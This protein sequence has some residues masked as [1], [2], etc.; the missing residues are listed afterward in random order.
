MKSQKTTGDN[1]YLYFFKD[2]NMEE[3]PDF[4]EIDPEL[5]NNVLRKNYDYFHLLIQYRDNVF[6]EKIREDIAK[7]YT[8]K[9]QV[10]MSESQVRNSSWGS[11]NKI[12][13][14][15][16]SWGTT[17]QWVYDYGYVYFENGRVTS[18]SER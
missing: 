16:Y 7:N 12:N 6:A 8:S 18:V 2:V 17:E 15:T 14:D 9:P 3:F 10:G 4:V 1:N 13:R 5:V 11:P